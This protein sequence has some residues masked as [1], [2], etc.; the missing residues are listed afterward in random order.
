MRAHKAGE[1]VEVTITYLEMTARP[2]Y[3]RPHIF[4]PKPAALVH[5]INPP[6]WYFLSLYDAVGQQYEWRDR[7]EQDPEELAEFVHDEK[8][9]I[10]T[11]L[12][13]GWIHGFFLLDHR[14]A[15]T[16]DIGYFG[17]VPEAI[18]QGLG[19][20][21]L[22]TAVHMGWDL[23]EIDRLTLNTCTLDHPRALSHYQKH[24]FAP[25]GQT[26]YERVLTRDWDPATFP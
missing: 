18:G 23:P 10:Y 4:G 22:Q 6:V 25:I 24:G 14:E 9:A 7:H 8:V 3:G 21:L 1:T 12:R 19:T 5:A 26:T 15:E 11:L 2:S 20:Y 16:C 17:L 13:D